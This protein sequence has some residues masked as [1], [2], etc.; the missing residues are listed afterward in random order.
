YTRCK[1]LVCLYEPVACAG[2]GT[3]GPC[4]DVGALAGSP[5]KWTRRK[6]CWPRQLPLPALSGG[7][8]AVARVISDGVVT[9][10]LFGRRVRLLRKCLD[11][12]RELF[13][14]TTQ[15]VGGFE[16][17]KPQ[18]HGQERFPHFRKAG[19]DKCLFIVGTGS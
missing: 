5:G 9:D 13:P 1:P 19:E 6:R 10:S 15:G 16:T 8:L 17:V 18:Q 3:G 12:A 11:L 2:C 7:S 4:A 14:R